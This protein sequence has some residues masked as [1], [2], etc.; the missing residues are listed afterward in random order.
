MWTTFPVDADTATCL[1]SGEMA[2][3]SA[4]WPSTTKRHTI[5]RV[6]R[7]IATTSARLGLETIKS[8]P[9]LVEY[10]SSTYWSLP[11]PTACRIARK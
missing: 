5:W 9:S 11:S 10:M 4:R 3:W 8:R 6:S 2:M 1:P 7:L